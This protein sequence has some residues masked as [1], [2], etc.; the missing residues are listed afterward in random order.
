MSSAH[1]QLVYRRQSRI[2]TRYAEII[3][4]TSQ[5]DGR[6]YRF[7]ET[8]FR[9]ASLFDGTR[10]LAEAVE[11]ARAQG[12]DTDIAAAKR[13]LSE[14]DRAGLLEAET[15]A[16]QTAAND[17]DLAEATPGEWNAER[18]N[19]E[20]EPLAKSRL[21]RQ[22]ALREART[23]DIAIHLP[24]RWL[25]WAGRLL[26]W[27]M[28]A[29]WR[30]AA[31]GVVLFCLGLG[32][33]NNRVGVWVDLQRLVGPW[34]IIQIAALGFFSVNLL[35]QIA[36]AA[37]YLRRV[38]NLPAFGITF[39]LRV[40]PRFYADVSPVIANHD[41]RFA[42]T[43]R[44]A[45]L[46]SSLVAMLS[47][48]VL[49]TLG[50]FVSRQSASHLPL[51]YA[52]VAVLSGWVFLL[53]LNP[54][55]RHEGY[56]LLATR[57]DTPDLRDVA[58]ASILGRGR[59][60]RRLKPTGVSTP[61]IRLYALA[62]VAWMGVVAWVLFH[63]VGVWL[64]REWAGLGVVLFLVLCGV[65]MWNPMKRTRARNKLAQEMEAR[66]PELAARRRKK[67]G[68]TV[69]KWGI[70]IAVL[71]LLALIPYTY[72]PTGDFKIL[73]NER[74]DVRALI[75]G[76]VR[77]VLVQEGQRVEP[78]QLLARLS[79]D[80]ERARVATS[81]ARLARLQAELA[82]A[83]RGAEPEEIALAEQR[84]ITAQRRYDSSKREAERLDSA[85]QRGAA[86]G[87][88]ANQAQ[89]QADLDRE[90]LAEAKNSL[91]VV[92]AGSSDEEITALKAS[93]SAEKATLAYARQQLE[94][95][96]IKAPRAGRVVSEDLRFAQG[97]YLARG[98]LLLSVE[99]TGKVLAEIKIPQNDIGDVEV[100]A[101]A[102][103]KAW[104]YPGVSFVGTVAGIA[105]NAEVSEY[106]RVVRVQ[107][108]IENADG[109]LRPEMTGHAKV[110]GDTQPAGLAFTRGLARF[111]MIE[112]WSWIP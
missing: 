41:Q 12:T 95:T 111:F 31:L 96:D 112:V 1:P 103:A 60:W 86:T 110:E 85:Y 54:M 7:D 3:L 79:D 87:Q 8:E 55:S 2:S 40:I 45:V 94:Y 19:R 73:P 56:Q 18:A 76:E 43:D 66:N 74:S 93:I 81:E 108:E 59:I 37:E 100:G 22:H 21:A 5:D 48:L 106:G 52:G 30:M 99:E 68:T 6:V 20:A 90:R 84:V 47:L 50:W 97:A 24:T 27:P 58:V 83:E 91:D 51:L 28:H 16:W 25:L 32:V 35:G 29:R 64:E 63:L 33:Y 75:A 78:G 11:V 61:V 92:R 10:S 17:S 65:A 69:I 15:A 82:L 88:V 72:E 13:F 57:L 4:L 70:G 49:A 80:E 42:T 102:S 89:A 105:P 53:R 34:A 77:E 109:R 71:L 26:N 67:R 107:M 39:M 46:G 36:R 14:L 101:P 104:A 62:V 38:G 44:M 9:L 98:D 23:P